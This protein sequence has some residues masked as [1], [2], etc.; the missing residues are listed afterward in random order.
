MKTD[1]TTTQVRE[2]LNFKKLSTSNGRIP[3][4]AATPY[5]SKKQSL[6]VQFWTPDQIASGQVENVSGTISTLVELY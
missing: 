3:V 5:S 4:I 1:N 6:G 2:G